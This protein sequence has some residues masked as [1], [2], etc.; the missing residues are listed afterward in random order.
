MTN[1]KY[2]ATLG[3]TRM[4]RKCK[5]CQREGHDVRTCPGT[6]AE[7]VE[8]TI[9][10]PPDS[11]HSTIDIPDN[12][13]ALWNAL[14]SQDYDHFQPYVE[15]IDNAIAAILG[16]S[17]HGRIYIHFD[18]TTNVGSIEHSGGTTFPLDKTELARCFTYGGKHATRLNEHGCGLKSSLAI[19]DRSNTSWNIYI[20]HVENGVRKVKRISA[21]YSSKMNL[22]EELEWSGTDQTVENGSYITFPIHKERFS[23]LYQKKTSARMEDLH[24]RIQCHFTHMWMKLEEFIEGKLQMTYNGTPLLPFSFGT[25]Q[26]SDYID[27]TKNGEFHLSTGGVVKIQHITL[28]EKASSRKLPGSYKFKRAMSANGAYFFKNGRFIESIH[29]DDTSRGNLYSAIFGSVP[30]NHHNGNIVLVSMSG[31]QDQLPP[32]VPTKNRF[33]SHALFD[34]TIELLSKNILKPGK[35][36]TGTEAVLASEYIKREENTIK[37]LYPHVL[38]EQEKSFPFPDGK[39]RTAPIDLV[40]SYNKTRELIEF[41]RGFRPTKD[42]IG[43]LFT[44]WSVVRHLPE[45]AEWDLKPTLIYCATKTTDNIIGESIRSMLEILA[46]VGFHPVLRNMENETLWPRG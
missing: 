32:T 35:S 33:Q 13:Y 23:D 38:F 14:S 41:K 27:K 43:Q 40:I 28:N 12:T 45:N 26:L 46:D 10:V 31:L 6:P 19:M 2:L 16:T 9:P 42:D 20:K 7:P 22:F 24:E 8:P 3:I 36:T 21:P 18:F 17:G 5:Q 44:N 34:E 30:D 1:P 25:E 37:R 29:T 15:L 39:S 4:P 11:E